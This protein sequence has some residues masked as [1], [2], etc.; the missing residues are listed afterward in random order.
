ME[1]I[2]DGLEPTRSRTDL[3]EW[4]R[5]QLD[6]ALKQVDRG[7]NWADGAESSVLHYAAVTGVREARIEP[8][9]PIETRPDDS[10]DDAGDDSGDSENGDGDNPPIEPI[11]PEDEN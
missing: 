10:N 8:I 3:S 6:N 5:E 11:E 7:A 2:A 1:W 4:E 9:E